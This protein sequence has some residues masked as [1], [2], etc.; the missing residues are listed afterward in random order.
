MRAR[1]GSRAGIA[2]APGLGLLAGA[3][4]ALT[5]PDHVADVV[6]FAARRGRRA[7]RMG[8]SWGLGHALAAT[9]AMAPRAEVPRLEQTLSA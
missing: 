2:S 3:V 5:G 1:V 6:P 8:A 7:W 4:L 9:I